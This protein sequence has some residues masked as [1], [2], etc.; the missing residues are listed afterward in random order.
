MSARGVPRLAPASVL[1]VVREGGF[2]AMPGL[3]RPRRIECGKLSQRQRERLQRLLEEI[4]RLDPGEPAA[5][6]ADR[7][8]FRL[9]LEQPEAECWQCALDE[10]QAPRGVVGLWQHGPGALD[11]PDT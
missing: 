7:R 3:E 4:D 2:A 6:G 11:E 1:A 9:F 8:V 5:A 10:T